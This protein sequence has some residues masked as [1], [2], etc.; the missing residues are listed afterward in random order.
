M[1]EDRVPCGSTESGKSALKYLRSTELTATCIAVCP[2]GLRSMVPPAAIIPESTGNCSFLIVIFLSAKLAST[3][4]SPK[5]WSPKATEETVPFTS[6]AG[7]FTVPPKPTVPLR[8]PAKRPFI[9]SSLE[10]ID[11]IFLISA[12]DTVILPKR[13]LGSLSLTPPAKL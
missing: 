3:V 2:P 8:R 9:D 7:L 10:N 11:I 12:L 4:P 5:T 1:T 6:R 13:F